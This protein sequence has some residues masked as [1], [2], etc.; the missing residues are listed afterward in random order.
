MLKRFIFFLLLGCLAASTYAQSQPLPFNQ[1]YYLYFVFESTCSGCLRI[2]PMLI[3]F[4]RKH[5]ITI[6]GI[7][8]NG[9]PLRTWN[10]A[11]TTDRNGVVYRLGVESA[12]TP[13]LVLRDSVTKQNLG[14]GVGIPTEQQLIERIYQL[15]NIRLEDHG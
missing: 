12:P 4:A 1:R 15:T 3:E 14:I 9:K 13:A 6:Q 7:S 8:K 5:Q 11:W 2:A 10:G